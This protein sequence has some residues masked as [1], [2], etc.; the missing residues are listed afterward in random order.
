MAATL[1]ERAVSHA[2]ELL[3]L[4][5]DALTAAQDVKLDVQA[6]WDAYQAARIAHERA[7]RLLRAEQTAQEPE[8]ELTLVGA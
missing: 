2:A 6:E 3:E 1:M 5:G 8:R 4:A 7:C